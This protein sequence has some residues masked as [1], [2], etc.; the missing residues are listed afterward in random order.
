MSTP[1][2]AHRKL[3]DEIVF[4]VAHDDHK[5]EAAQLL[6]DSEARAVE[7]ATKHVDL[8]VDE[9][10]RIRVCYQAT[11]EIKGLCDRAISNTYQHF[12]VIVQRDKAEQ[13]LTAERERVRVLEEALREIA[14]YDDK[15]DGCCPYGCDTP[16]IAHN[17]LA[18]PERKEGSG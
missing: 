10:K 12:P 5:G 16:T 17:A 4:L 6:A 3:V 13:S 1:T 18:T 8:M 9:F 14:A 7:A 15:H 11:K 2:E